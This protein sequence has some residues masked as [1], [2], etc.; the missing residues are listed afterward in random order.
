MHQS[1]PWMVGLASL[2]RIRGQRE[3]RVAP[4][5]E[6]KVRFRVS[7]NTETAL[8]WKQE[9]EPQGNNR[10]CQEVVELPAESGLGSLNQ[11][12]VNFKGTLTPGYHLW[13]SLWSTGT[14]G[15]ESSAFPGAWEVS[16]D[17]IRFCFGFYLFSKHLSSLKSDIF[18][19][20][21]KNNFKCILN[22]IKSLF[23][24]KAIPLQVIEWHQDW[25]TPDAGSECAQKTGRPPNGLYCRCSLKLL[26]T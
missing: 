21:I 9:H 24:W 6:I 23:W 8:R 1:L 5:A 25:V 10:N 22:E 20:L 3:I 26:W 18:T 4:G 16:S 13:S 19:R 2:L 12:S 7:R 11:L 17:F 14:K 15:T